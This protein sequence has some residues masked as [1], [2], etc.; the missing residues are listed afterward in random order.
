MVTNLA[1]GAGEG[2]VSA[3]NYAWQMMMLPHGVCRAQHLDR[4]LPDAWPGTTRQG[5]STRCQAIV[6]PRAHTAALSDD[7]GVDRALRVP[8]WRLPQ[9][10]F[11]S[12]PSTRTRHVL[13]APALGFLAV[14][15]VWYALVEVLT[16]I[17]YAMQDTVTPVVAGIVII[18]VNM[19]WACVL[20]DRIGHVGLALALSVSTGIEAVILVVVLRRRIGGFDPIVRRAGSAG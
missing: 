10:L 20:V 19:I 15:L 3:L 17:F 7:P 9:T 16:R 1:S 6:H 4:D 5:D 13:V 11:S 2:R 8:D 18:V 14:G 12:A